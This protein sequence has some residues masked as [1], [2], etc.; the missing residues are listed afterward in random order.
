MGLRA[1]WSAVQMP[2]LRLSGK[3]VRDWNVLVMHAL[4]R[5]FRGIL[6]CGLTRPFLYGLSLSCL[7]WRC[8]LLL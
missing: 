4:I 2:F 1:R 8:C 6:R 7:G 5:S 3:L